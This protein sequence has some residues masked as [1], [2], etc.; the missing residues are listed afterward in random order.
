MAATIVRLVLATAVN[1]LAPAPLRRMPRAR[2]HA[3]GRSDG[4]GEGI[5]GCGGE[6]EG[7]RA[8]GAG[9]REGAHSL[10]EEARKEE[11]REEGGGRRAAGE[12]R[13]EEGGGRK[14]GRGWGRRNTTERGAPLKREK[15]Q[16]RP[17][18]LRTAAAAAAAARREP[19]AGGVPSGEGAPPLPPA[20]VDVDADAEAAGRRWLA[21]TAAA[22]APPLGAGV[23]GADLGPD[24]TAL[25]AAA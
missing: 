25:A 15:R 10:N 13:R 9:G 4:A 23:Y 8:R 19:P 14:P 18:Y 2:Q 24:V 6:G 5:E 22:L 1:R 20:A 3:G 17:V 11:R 12:G 16:H 7:G 21:A